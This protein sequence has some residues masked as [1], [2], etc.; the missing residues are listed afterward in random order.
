LEEV[1]VEEQLEPYVKV[2]QQ[3]EL[4]LKERQSMLL[5]E[6]FSSFVH[7]LMLFINFSSDCQ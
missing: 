5:R 7:I 1:A 2:G 4:R 3:L 6:E